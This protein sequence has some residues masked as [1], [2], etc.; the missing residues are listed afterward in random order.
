MKK[1]LLT[2]AAI[3][4]LSLFAKAQPRNGFTYSEIKTEFAGSKMETKV[5]ED[6]ITY[7]ILDGTDMFTMFYFDK[8]GECYMSVIAPQTMGMLNGIVQMYN[9]KYVIISATE[10]KMYNNLG[11]I[12]ITLNNNEGSS[13]FI[14]R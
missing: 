2:G 14:W 11:H 12:S 3:V 1:L 5:D 10:W 8:D 6:G 13:F 4:A 7:L 9:Q